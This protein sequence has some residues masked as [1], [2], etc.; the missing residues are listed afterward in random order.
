MTKQELVNRF[1][2]GEKGRNHNAN[3]IAVNGVSMGFKLYDTIIVEVV[4][5]RVYFNHGGFKT[6]TTKSYMNLILDGMSSYKITQKD[7]G[8]YFNGSIPFSHVDYLDLDSGCLKIK[9]GCKQYAYGYTK[10]LDNYNEL[11]NIPF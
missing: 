7:G 10:V 8:W 3:I 4:G 11:E 1:L 2:E 5:R 6:A 9:D